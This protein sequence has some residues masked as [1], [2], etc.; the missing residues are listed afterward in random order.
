[1]AG[2]LGFPKKDSLSV[3]FKGPPP[4]KSVESTNGK[5]QSQNATSYGEQLKQEEKLHQGAS[6]GTIRGPLM[7]PSGQ[8]QDTLA[9]LL[10]GTACRV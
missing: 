10:L 6:K 2:H 1:M 9:L 8:T 7:D 5:I 3:C 4:K